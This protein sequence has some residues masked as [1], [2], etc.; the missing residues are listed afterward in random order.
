MRGCAGS[1]GTSCCDRVPA[2][3]ALDACISVPILPS[4]AILSIKMFHPI[5]SHTDNDA[6]RKQWL[7]QPIAIGSIDRVCPA[8][9]FSTQ[10]PTALDPWR[11]VVV[12]NAS[13]DIAGNCLP[14]VWH[15][16]AEMLRCCV[17]LLLGNNMLNCTR[18]EPAAWRCSAKLS[19]L[20]TRCVGGLW[21]F[22]AW[23]RAL[24]K[25][26]FAGKLQNL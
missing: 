26:S 18:V 14:I 15:S 2:A 25:Y 21:G 10:T 20:S 6:F 1:S 23:R 19:V 8:L 3:K 11:F 17:R 9:H 13:V 5:P 12:A 22:E 16:N 7:F 24:G 4:A